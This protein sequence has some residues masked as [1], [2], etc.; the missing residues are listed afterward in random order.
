MG[1]RC[2]VARI[3]VTPRR[4]PIRPLLARWA[5]AAARSRDTNSDIA[6]HSS[7]RPPED[8]ISAHRTAPLYVPG[9]HRVGS[10]PQR[11]H[12]GRLHRQGPRDDPAHQKGKLEQVGF[13]QRRPGP[14][15]LDRLLDRVGDVIACSIASSAVVSVAPATL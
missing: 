13:G 6:R 1:A 11:Q 8:P 3:G 4:H 14:H 12:T 15:L 5:V 7:R 2:P 9:R 10:S